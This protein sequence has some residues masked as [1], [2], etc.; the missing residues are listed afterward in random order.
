[1]Y[2]ALPAAAVG[3]AAPTVCGVDRFRPG[4]FTWLNEMTCDGAFTF[5]VYV[6]AVVIPLMSFCPVNETYVPITLPT[7]WICPLD[8]I[9]KFGA[10][11]VAAMLPTGVGG[12]I[13]PPAFVYALP[14][15]AVHSAAEPQAQTSCRLSELKSPVSC[16]QCECQYAFSVWASFT[17]GPATLIE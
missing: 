5:G 11:I 4:R 9:D 14:Y 16:T 17:P 8:V 10:W 12:S 15:N 1:M 3:N 13:V 2:D 7:F 6:F